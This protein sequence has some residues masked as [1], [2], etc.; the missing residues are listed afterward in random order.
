MHSIGTIPAR[1]AVTTANPISVAQE[2]LEGET[3]FSLLIKAVGATNR[4]GGAPTWGPY[5][6]TQANATQKAAASPEASAE[7]WYLLNALPRTD[8]LII[9]NTGALSIYYQIV[10]A[11]AKAGSRSALDLTGGANGTSTNPAPGSITTSENGD[12]IVSCNAN[13]ATTW[14]PSAQAGTNISNNDDG[15]HG[16]GAQYLLQS[17]KG[18]INLGWTFSTSDDWGAVV[19]AF[20]EVPFP[21][22]NNY[23]GVKVPDGWGG[24]D[25]IR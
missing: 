22:F 10:M 14:A 18:A 6:F 23:V 24:S 9:P 12:F 4:A 8:D 21:G 15:A 25:R 11:R 1:S 13:G 19:A 20:K 3:V 7:I 16:W 2:L 5:T 17:T